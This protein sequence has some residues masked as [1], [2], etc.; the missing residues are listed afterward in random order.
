[1]GVFHADLVGIQVRALRAARRRARLVVH[2][3]D[4]MDEVTLA[5]PTLVGELATAW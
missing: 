4:G 3:R 2:G 5:G 1:M